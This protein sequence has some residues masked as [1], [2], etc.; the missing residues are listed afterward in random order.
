MSGATYVRYELVRTFRARRFFFISLVFPVV[1]YYMIAAPN[2]DEHDLAGTGLSAPLYFMVGLAS[3]GA[4]NAMLGA[5]ARIAGER[6]VGWNRHLRLTPLAPRTYFRT[7]VLAGYMMAASTVLLLY[8]AGASLGVSLSSAEWLRMTG[9][10]AVGLIPFAG[11]GILFGHLLTVDAIGPTMGGTTALLSILGGV[12]FPITNGALHDL[13]LCLPSY[14]LVQAS[15]V[16][17]G[18]KGWGVT[19][20]LVVAAWSAAFAALAMWAYRRDTQRV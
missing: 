10:L 15:H 7:K 20:W 4:M 19:G 14:W 12:W 8:S 16:A 2:R 13:A 1:L 9:L 3:F 11:L 6:Q 18:G 17:L 5:G